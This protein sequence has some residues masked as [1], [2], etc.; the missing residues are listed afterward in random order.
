MPQANAA[1]RTPILVPIGASGADILPPT[2]PPV[3]VILARRFGFAWL[4]TLLCC[5]SYPIVALG[6]INFYRNPDSAWVECI[7]R[8][9]EV[10][11]QRRTAP[12]PR[13]FLVGGSNVQFGIDAE[14][15]ER[16]LNIPAINFG[17]HAGMGFTYMLDRAQRHLRS[18]DTVVLCPEYSAW[19]H[20]PRYSNTPSFQYTW[21]YDRRYVLRQP[22]SE[23]LRMVGQLRLKDWTDSARGWVVRLQDK[24]FKFADLV[25]YNA[26]SLS[27]N[28]DNRWVPAGRPFPKYGYVFPTADLP[29]VKALKEFAAQAR[30]KNIRLLFTWCNFRRPE[31]ESAALQPPPAWFTDL[32]RD[33]GIPMLDAPADD[34]FPTAWFLDTE[35][36]ATQP[37][38]RL[39]TEELI[40][41][42]RP[43][44]GLAP[45]PDDATGVLLVVGQKHRLSPGNLFADKPAVRTRYLVPEAESNDPRAITAAGVAQLVAGGTPVYVND[46]D[47]AGPL[48]AT[49][50]LM[51]EMK[52]QERETIGQWFEKHPSHLLLIA[53]ASD[54]QLSPEWQAAVPA[55]VHRAL[56]SGGPV[57]A[58]FGTGS[59]AGVEKVVSAAPS[60]DFTS[61][62][63]ALLPGSNAMVGIIALHSGSNEK[64]VAARIAVDAGDF[65][66]T[67]RGVCVVA[68]D[69]V[70]GTVVD[71]VTFD[72]NAT[73]VKLWQLDR[74]V[75]VKDKE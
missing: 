40:R 12:G 4:L 50:G 44:V 72:N 63:P 65:C 16:K 35:Y 9:K 7:Y 11:V 48:L 10:A 5:C 52:A 22:V 53:A 21:T 64:D 67:A 41:Q 13:I 62:L 59:F 49:A 28:G 74:V 23:I 29:T 14:L 73:D 56:T 27:P 39:R 69:P 46:E 32:L 54:R 57:V 61:K 45:A 38:R 1:I 68:V 55:N 6:W 3:R 51:L 66:T 15:I 30:A 60:A 75:P 58:L 18:G 20:A 8:Q 31:P 17:T 33:C 71:T 70:M 43:H 19:T 2:V 47:P 36:H 24:Q 42:I 37:C 34:A 25:R 26:A